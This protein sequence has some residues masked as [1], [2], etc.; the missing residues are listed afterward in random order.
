[1]RAVTGQKQLLTEKYD[2]LKSILRNCGSVAVAFSGGVDST[3]L[4]A[5]ARETLGDR[6][7]AVNVRSVFTPERET[8]EAVKFC[9]SRGIPL[10]TIERD[11]LN[12][13]GVAENPPARCYLCKRAIFTEVLRMA[14]ETGFA[15][16]AEGSNTDDTGDYRPGMRAIEELGVRSPLLEAGLSKRDIR[17]LS[18]RM[19]LPTAGKP[20]MAC[21]ASRVPYGE[22]ITPEKLAMADRA[23]RFLSEMGFSQFR[24]R[25]HG[26]VARIEVLSED[27]PRFA[28]EKLR[29]RI[30][31]EFRAAGFSY[32]AL[33]LL[34][35]RT[36]S[37]N[38]TLAEKKD[39][40]SVDG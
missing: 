10:M 17:E 15:C 11:I 7:A 38:E 31:E 16:V 6:A 9:E 37:L 4:L 40:G 22:R 26:T 13:P 33:D 39:N 21:L 28:D 3:F 18:A 36:G 30:Y 2:R 19:G 1:M 34:G 20:S 23:E 29:R 14:R 24:V 32:T 25:V 12:V 5:A 27:I 8:A 35:Y